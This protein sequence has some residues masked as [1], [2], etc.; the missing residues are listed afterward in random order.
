M[1]VLRAT[2]I[3]ADGG[4]GVVTDVTANYTIYKSGSLY[5]AEGDGFDTDA[6][7]TDLI[8]RVMLT[9]ATRTLRMVIN[10]VGE[11]SM[12]ATDGAIEIPDDTE[13]RVW[14]KLAGDG[15]VINYYI[16]NKDAGGS[17]NGN[18]RIYGPGHI[19]AGITSDPSG[20]TLRGCV[21]LE[22]VEY[23]HIEGLESSNTATHCISL[24]TVRG[25]TIHNCK[26]HGHGDDGISVL[27][28]S[29]SVSAQGIVTNN[30][31]YNYQYTWKPG[32]DGGGSGIE[33]EERTGFTTVANNNIHTGYSSD[34]DGTGLGHGIQFVID[35]GSSASGNFEGVSITGNSINGVGTTG[36]TD[37]FLGI[38]VMYRDTWQSGTKPD[39]AWVDDEPTL[40]FGK[41]VSVVGNTVSDVTYGSGIKLERIRGASVVGNSVDGVESTGILVAACQSTSVTGNNINDTGSY[42][43]SST[44]GSFIYPGAQGRGNII[45]NNTIR[46]P[47]TNASKVA[48]IN[49]SRV[50]SPIVTGNQVYEDR[51]PANYGCNNIIRAFD[52]VG[53]LFADANTIY[54]Y[55]TTTADNAIQLTGS[56]VTQLT[57]GLCSL[58]GGAAASSNRI[59]TPVLDEQDLSNDDHWASAGAAVTARGIRTFTT[60]GTVASGVVT[61]YVG[62]SELVTSLRTHTYYRVE[63]GTM[64]TD[65]GAPN[66]EVRGRPTNS[67]SGT[68]LLTAAGSA[69]FYS[70]ESDYPQIYLRAGTAVGSEVHTFTGFSVIEVDMDLIDVDVNLTV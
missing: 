66:W 63:V 23:V 3:G 44:A 40:G 34:A 31:I 22:D 24:N 39:A 43:I 45:S 41:T 12:V 37:V 4:G 53:R 48:A 65:G 18:I 1:G 27:G 54:T 62:A 56:N 55:K 26:L 20:G 69:T 16:T 10:L 15:G 42:A 14:G 58:D 32:T 33:I 9:D 21:H 11:L 36:T 2:Q 70:G 8:N 17:G 61:K 38:A 28:S 46:N 50:F 51:G 30:E 47:G 13:L 29:S 59:M 67:G 57:E 64:Q 25:Y 6:S 35:P 5:I 68:T 49:L 7:F 52:V 19:S 60:D